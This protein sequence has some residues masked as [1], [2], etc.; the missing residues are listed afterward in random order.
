MTASEPQFASAELLTQLNDTLARQKKS[1]L[2]EGEVTAE[3]RIDRIN[4]AIDA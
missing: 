4:R 1:Y 2:D 3:V